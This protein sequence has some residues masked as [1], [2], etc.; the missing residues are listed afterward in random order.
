MARA[1][2]RSARPARRGPRIE[3]ARRGPLASMRSVRLAEAPRW[4]RRVGRHDPPVVDAVGHQPGDRQ[5][6]LVGDRADHPAVDDHGVGDRTPRLRDAIPGQR[7][8][9][10]PAVGRRL[11]QVDRRPVPAGDDQPPR[12]GDALD[13]RDHRVAVA[14]GRGEQAAPPG[15]RAPSAGSLSAD[16]G[17]DRLGDLEAAGVHRRHAGAAANHATIGLRG[18]ADRHGGRGRRRVRGAERERRAQHVEVAAGR[19]TACARSCV[20]EAKIASPPPATSTRRRGRRPRRRTPPPATSRAGRRPSRPA[21][22]RARGSWRRRRRPGGRSP[23]RSSSRRRCRP[24]AGR[25]RRRVC[26]TSSLLRSCGIVDATAWKH[27]AG[28]DV[29]GLAPGRQRGAVGRGGDPRAARAAAR[30]GAGRDVEHAGH[31]RERRG[32]AVERRRPDVA[33][34]GPDDVAD[35]VDRQVDRRGRGRPTP[36]RPGPASRCPWRRRTTV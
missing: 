32:G 34:R 2:N 5:A 33:A 6:R 4:P 36:S 11:D 22:G 21:A 29:A 1:T 20:S 9:P 28:V 12:R 25:R 30:V 35:A 19:R 26:P 16:L 13:E 17:L 8:G 10:A 7:V 27:P 14:V 24:P 3:S 15:R 31:G 23:R 18:L